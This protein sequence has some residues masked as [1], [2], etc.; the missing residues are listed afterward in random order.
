MLISYQTPRFLFVHVYKAAGKSVTAALEACGQR[1]PRDNI[2]APDH[3][4]HVS[5]RSLKAALPT[6]VWEQSFKFAFVRN[7]WDRLLSLYEFIRAREANRDHELVCSLG[8]FGSFV[9][10]MCSARDAEVPIKRTQADLVMAEDGAPLLDFVGRFEHLAR[11]FSE[12]CRRLGVQMELPH[13][14]QTPHAPYQQAYDAVARDRVADWY[15]AEI[16]CFG[17]TFGG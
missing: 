1:A 12:V 13:L 14:N 16:E 2:F 3:T 6:E 9:E 15:A 11:D 7:P 4:Q 5:A 17:Y 8:G 10:W